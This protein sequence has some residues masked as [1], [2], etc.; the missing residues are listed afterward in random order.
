MEGRV[1]SR[2]PDGLGDWEVSE[3]LPGLV[4][5]GENLSS[6]SGIRVAGSGGRLLVAMVGLGLPLGWDGT[7]RGFSQGFGS[8]AF[9]P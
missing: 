5:A 3:R 1:G 2:P 9:P 4:K 8:P 6:M 7:S